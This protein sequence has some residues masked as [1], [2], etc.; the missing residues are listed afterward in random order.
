MSPFA[1]RAFFLAFLIL[2]NGERRTSAVSIEPQEGLVAGRRGQLADMRVRAPANLQTCERSTV[3]AGCQ[4]LLG[5]FQPDC[6]H[7]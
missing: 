3:T 5:D 4:E 6:S 2:E 1:M 7:Y